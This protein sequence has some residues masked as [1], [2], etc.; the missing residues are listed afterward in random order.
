M[1]SAKPKFWDFWNSHID[2][3]LPH[4]TPP[5]LSTASTTMLPIDMLRALVMLLLPPVVYML[6]GPARGFAAAFGGGGGAAPLRGAA[7]A[8]ALPQMGTQGSSQATKKTKAAAVA[9]F[10]KFLLTTNG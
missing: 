7:D 8:D 5:T 6:P 9:C 2:P 4:F 1:F 10:N 3:T